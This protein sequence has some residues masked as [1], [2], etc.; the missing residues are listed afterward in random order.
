MIKRWDQR[1]HLREIETSVSAHPSVSQTIALSRP[2]PAGD[3]RQNLVCLFVIPEVDGAPLDRESLILTCK[4]KLSP[5]KIPD[6]I[7]ILNGDIRYTTS[8]KIDRQAL[9]RLWESDIS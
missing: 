4:Q 9:L 1:L 8:A 6:D 2:A 5:Y 7:I 3:P